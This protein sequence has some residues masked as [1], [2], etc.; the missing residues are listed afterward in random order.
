MSSREIS[1]FRPLK[2]FILLPISDWGQVFRGDF[3]GSVYKFTQSEKYPIYLKLE[4]FEDEKLAKDILFSCG[5]IPFQGKE[6]DLQKLLDNPKES[7][8]YIKLKAAS[9]KIAAQIGSTSSVDQ[10]GAESISPRGSFKIY[11][12][13]GMSMLIYA[14][15]SKEWELA[16]MPHFFAESNAAIARVVINRILSWA[17]APM[18]I[19]GFWGEVIKDGLVIR[20]AREAHGE[21]CFVDLRRMMIIHAQGESPIKSSFNFVRPDRTLKDRMIT[22]RAEE[23]FSFLCSKTTYFDFQGLSVAVRQ[24]LQQMSRVLIGIVYPEEKFISARSQETRAAQQ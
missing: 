9:F 14:S 1:H 12:Y 3:M 13:A 16:A 5:F 23:L 24:I 10:Y 4:D 18:G 8:K 22:M 7:C 17:L 2:F 20:N 15:T 19:V 6:E 11:R 21:A